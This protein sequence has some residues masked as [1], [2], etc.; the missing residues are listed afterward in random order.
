MRS[1]RKLDMAKLR[2]IF[3]EQYR[4]GPSRFMER[5]KA[6][7]IVVYVMCGGGLIGRSHAEQPRNAYVGDRVSKRPYPRRSIAQATA[8]LALMAEIAG[9]NHLPEM[10]DIHGSGVF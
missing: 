2:E 5:L 6:Q 10:V 1:F 7:Q 3:A 8:V 4:E 9:L